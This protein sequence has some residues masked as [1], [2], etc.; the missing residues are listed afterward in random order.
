M[1][2]RGDL[3]IFWSTVP[4]GLDRLQGHL[5]CRHNQATFAFVNHI[6]KNPFQNI[7][8]FHFANSQLVKLEALLQYLKQKGS[9]QDI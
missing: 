5:V 8:S 4:V 7:L 1:I 3:H 6:S 9:F 2:A